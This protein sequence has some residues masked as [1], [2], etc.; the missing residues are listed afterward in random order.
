LTVPSAA[1]LAAE[2]F[3]DEVIA[4]ILAARRSVGS[5]LPDASVS[6]RR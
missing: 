5:S 1:L 4:A 2:Q 6:G 3:A